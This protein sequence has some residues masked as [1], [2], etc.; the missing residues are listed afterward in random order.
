MKKRNVV[1]ASDGGDE[2]ED[3]DRDGIALRFQLVLDWQFWIWEW[4]VGR[5]V[6]PKSHVGQCLVSR[7]PMGELDCIGLTANWYALLFAVAAKCD[8]KTLD[9]I[10]RDG[11]EA[12]CVSMD[13]LL[14]VYDSLGG[15]WGI[16]EFE[17][18]TTKN[19]RDIRRNLNRSLKKAGIERDVVRYDRKLGFYMA[20][21]PEKVRICRPANPDG[22]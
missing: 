21:D 10:E 14:E 13:E 8:G 9:D 7:A 1:A 18:I 4:F 17:D 12:I 15:D 2:R 20:V 11:L 16:P 3:R 6:R 5:R 19:V 22:A